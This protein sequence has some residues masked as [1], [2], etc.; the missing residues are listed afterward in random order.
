MLPL[1]LR[2]IGA[3]VETDAVYTTQNELRQVTIRLK[4]MPCIPSIIIHEVHAQ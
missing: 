1:S 2:C 4:D 3:T